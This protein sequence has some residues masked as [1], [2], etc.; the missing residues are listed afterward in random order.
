MNKKNL[1]HKIKKN[2]KREEIILEIQKKI[3]FHQIHRKMQRSV[4]EVHQIN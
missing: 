2:D 4:K 3:K 1:P